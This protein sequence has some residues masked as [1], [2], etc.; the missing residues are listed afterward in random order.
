MEQFPPFVRHCTFYTSTT[1]GPTFELFLYNL[2]D[3]Q[4]GY[5]LRQAGRIIFESGDDFFCTPA[6]MLLDETAKAI[7]GDLCQR[8]GG[9]EVQ[10]TFRREHA[11]LVW[12]A[13]V[14]RWP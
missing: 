13:V 7:M 12:A 4:L 3:E 8:Y 9:N 5:R 6:E 2:G 1:S 11:D 10:E 14:A